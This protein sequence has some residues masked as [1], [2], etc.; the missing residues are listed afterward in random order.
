LYSALLGI[1]RILFVDGLEQGIMIEVA[2]GSKDRPRSYLAVA[3]EVGHMDSE[4]RKISP[5]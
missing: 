5:V 1:G 4:S 3:W 2:I